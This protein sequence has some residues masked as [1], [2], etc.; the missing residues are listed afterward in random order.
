MKKIM[1]ELRPV[2]RGWFN[3]FQ[4]SHRWVFP[5]LDKWIRGRLRSILRHRHGGQG[6]GQGHDHYRWRNSTFTDLGLFSLEAAWTS[7]KSLRHG[8][9]H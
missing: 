3:Y 9:T 7:A 1:G 2:M 5:T 4:H 8:A 6:R